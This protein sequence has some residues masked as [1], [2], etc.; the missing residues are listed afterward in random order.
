LQSQVGETGNVT[1][2]KQTSDPVLIF[3]ETNVEWILRE[4]LTS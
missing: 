4:V 3:Y 1:F 2:Q